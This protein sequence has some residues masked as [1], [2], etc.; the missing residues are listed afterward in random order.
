MKFKFSKW[1]NLWPDEQNYL[2][3][4]HSS[5]LE[6]AKV[7]GTSAKA[8]SPETMPNLAWLRPE[9]A[10]NS[11]FSQMLV[12][13]FMT[14]LV[15]QIGNSTSDETLDYAI[16]EIPSH[17][18][19]AITQ[20]IPHTQLIGLSYGITTYLGYWL[21]CFLIREELYFKDHVLP[22]E[23]VPQIL[24]A[25]WDA[26]CLDLLDGFA[27]QIFPVIKEK[28]WIQIAPVQWFFAHELFHGILASFP[29]EQ[30]R[31]IVSD[32]VGHDPTEVHHAEEHCCDMFALNSVRNYWQSLGVGAEEVNR[33]MASMFVALTFKPSVFRRASD[34]HPIIQ[35][36]LA[37][38]A[39]D[40]GFKD[41][42]YWA[43]DHFKFRGKSGVESVFQM[44]KQFDRWR[45]VYESSYVEH[46]N[47]LK[48]EVEEFRTQMQDQ[49]PGVRF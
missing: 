45:I 46:L 7:K 48:E 41:A 20:K 19:V 38:L 23:E 39:K 47:R 33:L 21:S 34:S 30:R 17:K 3:R 26:D 44:A 36:R 10:T 14:F 2:K 12:G 43:I 32:C 11:H 37:M 42:A 25:I 9:S 40:S 16:F 27:L 49:F 13:D 31:A 6:H 1:E 28:P 4:L 29:E 22:I 15:E 5:H 18:L 24:W 8:L 35:Q